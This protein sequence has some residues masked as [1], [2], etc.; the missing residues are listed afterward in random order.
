M[1]TP[2]SSLCV[3]GYLALF[4]LYFGI[5]RGVNALVGGGGDGGAVG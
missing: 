1:F 2:R 3:L 4:G 5:W